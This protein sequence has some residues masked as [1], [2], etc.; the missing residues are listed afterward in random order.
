MTE[1]E[2]RDCADPA[3]M[4]DFLRGPAREQKWGPF[5]LSATFPRDTASERKFRLFACACCCQIGDAIRDDRSRAAVFTAERF[6]DGS[7]TRE[8]L[9]AARTAAWQVVH[10]LQGV[11]IRGNSRAQNAARAIAYAAAHP[12]T[13]YARDAAANA[14][15]AAPSAAR[16]AD[17]EA[18]RDAT[19]AGS[20][21]SNA[22]GEALMA[23]AEEAAIAFAPAQVVLLRDIFGDPFRRSS[24]EPTWLAWEDGTVVRL[25]RGI[26]DERAFNRLPLLAD[27][28]LDAGCDDE[29]ILDHCRS[30]GPH[31][32]GCWVVDLILGRA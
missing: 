2:W 10:E 16:D 20:E 17:Y 11:P 7:A 31:V 27:A 4:L 8:E 13:R 24:V 19:N 23:S 26:Y 14:A 1:Q 28:L 9:D 3:P 25:A 30:G 18:Y 32:R 15:Y 5:G 22:A 29:I 21:V 6:A 12:S